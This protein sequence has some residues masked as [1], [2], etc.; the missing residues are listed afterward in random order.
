MCTWTPRGFSALH[1]SLKSR[2]HT[3]KEL[4]CSELEQ[5][6]SFLLQSKLRDLIHAV[7][8]VVEWF[9]LRLS[10]PWVLLCAFPSHEYTLKRLFPK[11]LLQ[12][13]V[14]MYFA[15]IDTSSP[16]N[17]RWCC[18]GLYFILLIYRVRSL[19]SPI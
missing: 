14:K 18:I 8:L 6:W 9:H 17:V 2:K 13:K 15:Y 16:I 5:A 1:Q 10:S 4:Q 11:A 12:G 19:C 3:W 7:G